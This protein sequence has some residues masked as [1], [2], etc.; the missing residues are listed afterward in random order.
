MQLEK[1]RGLETRVEVAG[2]LGFCIYNES[3]PHPGL[4]GLL[5]WHRV[6]ASRVTLVHLSNNLRV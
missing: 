1:F 5:R 6:D 4:D 3:H 2:R